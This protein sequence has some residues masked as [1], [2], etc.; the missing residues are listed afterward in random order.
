MTEHNEVD[1]QPRPVPTELDSGPMPTIPAMGGLAIMA[2]WKAAKRVGYGGPN[3]MVSRGE[4]A[5]HRPGTYR[6]SEEY[7]RLIDS[8]A[9]Q[10]HVR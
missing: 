2:A 4:V 8:L 6:F 9:E 7:Y 5:L 3:G 10:H 1:Q